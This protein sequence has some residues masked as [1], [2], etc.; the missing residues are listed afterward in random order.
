MAAVWV[1]IFHQMFIIAQ[2]ICMARAAMSMMLM[3]WGMWVA[4][5]IV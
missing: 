3:K 4:S 1:E 2:S 5:M